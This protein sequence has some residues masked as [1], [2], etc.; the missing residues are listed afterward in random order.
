MIGGRCSTGTSVARKGSGVPYPGRELDR[1]HLWQRV[2]IDVDAA[3]H[4]VEVDELLLD[5]VA[6][7]LPEHG[8]ERDVILALGSGS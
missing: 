2:E 8:C 4:I 7:A 1:E 5:E 6:L 3:G